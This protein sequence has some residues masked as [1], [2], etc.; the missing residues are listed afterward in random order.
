[1]KPLKKNFKLISFYRFVNIKNKK[2]IKKLLDNFFYGKIIRG[3]VLL[4]NEGVNGSLCGKTEDI[5]EAITLLKK[6]LKI[7]KIR[8]NTNETNFLPYNKMKVRLKDEIISFDKGRINIRNFKNNH[9][10][11][12]EWDN[13]I[14][15]KDLKI[16][17]T[18]N[19]YETTIGKFK[20]SI[21]PNIESFRD[22][23]KSIKKL[24]INKNDN[25]ALYCTGGIR[26]EK[27]AIHLKLNGYKNIYQLEGG[28]L[29]YLNY[30]K[31][32]RQKSL[33]KGECFVFDQRVAINK[34]LNKGKYDQCYGCRHPITLKD[35][36]SHKYKKGVYC[37]TCFNIR[38][39][40]QKNSSQSR[41]RQI[42]VANS[43]GN[44][45]S[46]KKIYS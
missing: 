16:I 4:S 25:I 36:N 13:L 42:E 2:K 40:K 45:H 38:S 6:N 22:L 39:D 24:E 17:D 21:N 19:I 35:K 30:K 27:A 46:F 44:T 7:R 29:N 34:N 1:M 15:K 10:H 3:T 43:L 28:I 14:N 31:K 33:W 23:P 8:I 26:C 32:T 41:Q 11:P 18:R 5:S 37:P 20:N 9:I 12:N